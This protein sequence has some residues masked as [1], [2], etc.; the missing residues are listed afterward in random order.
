M[1][2]GSEQPVFGA[3]S[4][5]AAYVALL[6]GMAVIGAP[7]QAHGIVLGLW[8]TE[9]L[10]IALPAAFALSVAGV[11]FGPYLGFRWITGKQALIAA[12][13]AAANQPVVSFLTWA[14]RLIVP[15]RWVADFDAK[16]RMLD[17][18]FAGNAV[19]MT[20]TVIL[21]APLGEELF[22]RGF[23]LP[24]L[25]RSWGIA[26]AVLVSGAL[27]SLLHLDPVGFLGLMEIGILLAAL[28]WW[29]GSLW[30]AIIGHA[31]N[32]GIAGGAFLLGWEDPDLPPPPW[33]LALGAVLLLIGVIGLVRVLRRPSPGE[34][35]AERRPSNWAA[36]GALAVVWI[37]SVVV[38]LSSFRRG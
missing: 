20:I 4:A 17:A 12:V 26:A 8:L 2:D 33:V 10:A 19:P 24:A 38:G 18:V 37:A 30:A 14:E 1:A 3:G 15:A 6:F 29:T 32:N 7:A 16:Q 21:A 31:V 35:A 22:F 28:R 5:F 23:A 11:R 27:F 13:V 9:A 36:A 34:A 25:R